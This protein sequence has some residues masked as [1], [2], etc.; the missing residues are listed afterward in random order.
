MD[1]YCFTLLFQKV[2]KAAIFYIASCSPYGFMDLEQILEEKLKLLQHN[3]ESQKYFIS[4]AILS[5]LQQ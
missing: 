5:D 4:K 2:L 1:F 3:K